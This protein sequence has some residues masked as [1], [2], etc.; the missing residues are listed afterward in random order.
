M[1]YIRFIIINLKL[2]Y[3]IR[4]LNK[5]RDIKRNAEMVLRMIEEMEKVK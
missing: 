2:K 4:V 1:K 5:I 3:N